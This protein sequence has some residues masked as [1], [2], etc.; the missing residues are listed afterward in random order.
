MVV[1]APKS[2]RQNKLGKKVIFEYFAP[3]AKRVTV[4]GTFNQW[5]PTETLLKK[6]RKGNW[7]ITLTLTP[8]RY[9]YRYRVDGSWQNDQRPVECVPNAF[10]AWNCVT[11]VH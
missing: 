1:R 11:E 4:A 5:H 2:L 7:K 8:G 9:E 6:D 3:Q 10:G